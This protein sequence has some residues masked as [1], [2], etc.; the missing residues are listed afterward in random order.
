MPSRLSML[1]KRLCRVHSRQQ[2]QTALWSMAL[3]LAL[4]M[5]SYDPGIYRCGWNEVYRCQLASC[6]EQRDLD[7]T[8][9]GLTI[10]GLAQPKFGSKKVYLAA[11]AVIIGT[12]FLPVFSTSLPILF[13]EALSTA[14]AAEIC[15]LV[16]R[17]YL[18]AFVNICWGFELL[19]SAGVVRA[20]LEL[21]IPLFLIACFAPESLWYLVKVG[22]EDD[23]RATTKRLAPSEYLTDQLV[24]RQIALMKHTI[25][26]EK[27]E[28]QGASF[29]DCFK[30]SNL[31]RIEIYWS[32]QNIINYATQYLQT[33]GMTE[34]G[35]FNMY[36]GITCCYIVGTAAC[37]Y[38][39]H[40]FGRRSI[41]IARVALLV[42]WHVTIGSLGTVN[43]TKA[44]LAIGAVMVIINFSTNATLFPATYT[45]AAEVQAT[46]V[47]A[48]TIVLGRG[49]YLISS[50]L[51]LRVELGCQVQLLLDGV[52]SHIIGVPM[53]PAS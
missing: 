8:M 40:H 38:I 6:A 11:M 5:E 18:T 46:R 36:L 47:K 52:L 25:E 3:S 45:I 19:F 43:S 23:A 44:T 21:D 16:M 20:S 35:A 10:N 27:A 24:D 39:M 4:V 17:R 49:V 30:G 50:V 22:R 1:T 34:D 32:G 41:Y 48:K 9:I 29:L 28:T 7:R 14:Y 53:V 15:P 33:D 31:R 37:W 2:L 51:R 13:G 26:M 12:I 42:V